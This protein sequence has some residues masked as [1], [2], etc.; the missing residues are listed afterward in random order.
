[1]NFEKLVLPPISI[2]GLYNKVLIETEGE[3]PFSNKQPEIVI[4]NNYS[5]FGN[6]KN[7]ISI[8]V[9]FVNEEII[10]DH[11]LKFISR[12][13]EACKTN[14]ED[15][16]ILNYSQQRI[17][18]KLL[19]EQL[20]PKYILLFGVSTEEISLPVNF[21]FFKPQEYDSITFLST[22]S[23]SELN[24]ENEDS[25]LLKSKL[26]VCLRKIFQV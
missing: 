23:L 7:H 19:R 6:H 8:I 17:E 11:H 10:P 9:N 5:Y 20:Q 18:I 26:W 25:K 16:A 14:A 13:M 21:P 4:G 1:M 24:Q 3:L 22:P 2:A 15:C 12:I